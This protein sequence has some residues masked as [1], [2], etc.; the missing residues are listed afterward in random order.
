M[1]DLWV[2]AGLKMRVSP[3]QCGRLGSTVVEQ[4]N[5]KTHFYPSV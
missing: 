5:V 1:C 2:H 4:K 3:A